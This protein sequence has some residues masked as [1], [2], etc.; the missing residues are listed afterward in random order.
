PT[1]GT[2]G[3]SAGGE[4][5]NG[6]FA[7]QADKGVLPGSFR[8][9]IT[10]SRKTGRKT[11]DRVSGELTDV[12]AQYLPPQ[13]NSNSKLTYEVKGGGENSFRVCVEFEMNP[14]RRLAVLLTSIGVC[15]FIERLFVAK[16]L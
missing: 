16:C 6:E 10:A 4:I 5:I 7:V 1:A 11:R 12:F 13:Y 3:P 2:T 14:C 8:V 9:E 15:I